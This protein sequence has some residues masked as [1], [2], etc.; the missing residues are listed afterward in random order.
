MLVHVLL[1]NI[2]N[3]DEGIHSIDINGKTI[4]LM[5]EEKDDAD[6]YCG[7]LEAQDF[8]IPSVEKIEREEIDIF[9]LNAGYEVR[10]V[11]KGFRPTTEEDRLLITPP[12]RNLEVESIIDENKTISK[13]SDSFEIDSFRKKLEDLI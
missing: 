10:L 7:L 1:Y 5:F 9:C 6:R 2:G 4:V 11:E 12:Q 8:P 13:D 3:E